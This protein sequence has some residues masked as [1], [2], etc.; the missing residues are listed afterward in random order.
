MH[1]VPESLPAAPVAADP[2]HDAFEPV[3]ELLRAES[4]T[5]FGTSRVRLVP[6][7]RSERPFSRLTRVRVQRLDQGGVDSQLFVK[8]Y[9]AT[10]ANR[11]MV[12]QRVCGDFESTL[13]IFRA[14][15]EWGD[16]GV[17]RPVACYPE[18]LA[19]VTEEAEG[20]TLQRYLETKM[21]WLRARANAAEVT[22]TMERLSRWIRVFQEIEGEDGTVAVDS[23][24][25]YVDVR[26]KRL[27]QHPVSGF[28]DATRATVLA[29]L[30]ALGRAVAEPDLRRV[31]V[32]A[33]MS[34]GN[35]LVSP[36]RVV[37]LDFA[38]AT[39]GTYLHDLA[40]VFVHL[41]TLGVKPQFGRAAIRRLQMALL[42]G[43][44]PALTPD[45]PLFRL[46][47]LMHR[48][49]HFTTLCVRPAPFKS[50][51]YNR[52]LRQHHRRL[53]ATELAASGRH[54]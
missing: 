45:H 19:I 54:R 23:L 35:V 42:R 8:L 48:I 32:H 36:G 44:D 49:N 11:G 6:F 10:D 1:S 51:L 34:L 47:V 16:L 28:T 2:K 40:R 4:T 13:R 24:R 50:R 18:H 3:L 7:D 33:D 17:V 37:V 22:S 20:T 26:L 9:H 53:L 27:V 12:R 15:Q 43:F 46:L 31:A 14:M 38:M 29:H 5:H 39:R 25:E 21:T 30:D 41:D 52:I